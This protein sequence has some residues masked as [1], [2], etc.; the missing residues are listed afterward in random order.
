MFSKARGSFN[1]FG[2]LSENTLSCRQSSDALTGS[3][4]LHLDLVLGP[5]SHKSMT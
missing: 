3:E 4:G 5:H 2:H 1:N